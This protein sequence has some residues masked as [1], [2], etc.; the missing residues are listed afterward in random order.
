MRILLTMEVSRL[1]TGYV[2]C[3]PLHKVILIALYATIFQA[4]KDSVNSSVPE[5]KLPSIDLTPDQL[6]FV[7]F[8]QVSSI[9]PMP[10]QI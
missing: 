10:N 3:A 1:P 7:A 8:S 9:L 2:L 6:F 5:V 4:Y